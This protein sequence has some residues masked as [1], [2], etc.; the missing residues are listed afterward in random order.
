MKFN[1]RERNK[2]LLTEKNNPPPVSTASM[3]LKNCHHYNSGQTVEM[4]LTWYCFNALVPFC[5]KQHVY[6]KC[7]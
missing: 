4:I 5:H 6:K 1:K 3:A 7:Y 2:N